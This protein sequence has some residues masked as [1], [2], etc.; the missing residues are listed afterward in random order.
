MG[1]DAN[2]SPVDKRDRPASKYSAAMELFVLDREARTKT[3]ADGDTTRLDAAHEALKN[4]L[5]ESHGRK[6]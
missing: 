3:I 5:I 1:W 2:G 6:T 4:C